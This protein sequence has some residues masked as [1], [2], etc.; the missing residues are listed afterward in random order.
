MTTMPISVS[1]TPI[2]LYP[3]LK[4]RKHVCIPINLS[5]ISLLSLQNLSLFIDSRMIR[6]SHPDINT[7]IRHEDAVINLERIRKAYHILGN[8]TLRSQYDLHRRQIHRELP[9]QVCF[10]AF[11]FHFHPVFCTYHEFQVMI[12]STNHMS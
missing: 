12:T 3:T 9:F 2:G 1:P 11:S 10:N 4:S 5:A 6:A 7:S 8:P